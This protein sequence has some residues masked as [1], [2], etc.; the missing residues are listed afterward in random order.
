MQEKY[1]IHGNGQTADCAP[2]GFTSHTMPGHSK[3]NWDKSRYSI[4]KLVEY[5][6]DLIPENALVF[7]HSLGGHI[8]L[9][10]ALKRSDI[11]L[12]V[13]GM[14][15]IASLAMMGE[16]MAPPDCFAK[17]QNPNRSLEDIREFCQFSSG[18]DKDA[19][20]QLISMAKQQDPMFNL[21]LFTDGIAN[22]D[23][24]EV[25]K[26]QSL[27]SRFLL[28]LSESEFAYL[29]KKVETLDLPMIKTNY[30]G[31]TPWLTDN[32]WIEWLE[33]E[34]LVKVNTSLT[35]QNAFETIQSRT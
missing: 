16:V 26:A 24:N 34:L 4:E 8:A 3:E 12:V 13:S 20:E 35:K 17:F 10:V 27:G 33:T 18:G 5:Y 9:N 19:E 23:W 6:I 7:G 1:F 28:I 2:R 30:R 14:A 31:H 15:P 25:E 29:P 11:F 21:T 32:N 22:Y